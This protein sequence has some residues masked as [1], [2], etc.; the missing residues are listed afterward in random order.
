MRKFTAALLV[1]AFT[2]VIVVPPAAQAATPQEEQLLLKKKKKLALEK[3]KKADETRKLALAKKQ[4]D[5]E[6][7]ASP[8]GKCKGFM[9]CLFGNKRGARFDRNRYF[10][11]ASLA[12]TTSAFA[13]KSRHTVAWNETKYAPGTIIVKTPERSLYYVLGD[14]KAIR[15]AVGVGREGFQW[16]GSSSI[17]S[18]QEWPSWT[19]PKRMIEREAAKGHYIPAFM[20]GGP[21]NPLGARA[22]YI[23]GTIFR[24]HGTNNE[25]SIG[26]AVSSGC[27]R[28]MNADVVDL[29]ERVKIGSRIYV[30]Q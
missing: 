28:M 6:P 9:K 8:A 24:V 4:K 14:G 25:A 11:N 18:K 7:T 13:K 1:A 10:Q 17:V 12:G 23:G 15:Y 19:P 16:S 3:K 30:Y 20:E 26:G 22:M 2:T 27:I 29:Y 5:N 21:G